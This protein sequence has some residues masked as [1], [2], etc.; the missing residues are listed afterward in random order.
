[1]VVLILAIAVILLIASQTYVETT[2][3]FHRLPNDNSIQINIKALFGIIKLKYKI[4]YLEILLQKFD[5][6]S[7]D[8]KDRSANGAMDLYKNI[9]TYILSNAKV[10]CIKCNIVVGLDDAYY[11]AI[12]TGLIWAL[13]G[14]LISILAVHNTIDDLDINI[15]PNYRSMSFDIDLYC[16]IKTKTVNI[17]IAGIK[18]AHIYIKYKMF[19][20]GGDTYGRSSYSGVDENHNG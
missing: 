15:N 18:A 10:D 2:F 1:V 19:K 16:I 4:N 6:K 7:K 17:I 5:K 3:V 14:S 12:T 8:K 13:F 11:T 9:L 20:K